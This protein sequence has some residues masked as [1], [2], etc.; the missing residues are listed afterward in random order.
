M[1]DEQQPEA[2]SPASPQT[3]GPVSRRMLL[4]GAAPAIVTL[5]SGAALAQS[6]NLISAPPA[7]MAE[8]NK[9]RC[10]DTASVYPTDKPNV[11]DLGTTPMAHV[12]Q[13]RSTKDYFPTG[14][15]GDYPSG[16][17]VTAKQMCTSGGQYVRQDNWGYTR[18]NVSRGV[19]VSATA[20]NSFS[21]KVTYTDI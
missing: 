19:L 20:I 6:S 16:S 15:F 4:R 17:E 8:D 2:G 5:Y 7:A 11:Y 14:G 3:Q 18:V 13:I 9:Y 1:T 10:L 21:D 12:T